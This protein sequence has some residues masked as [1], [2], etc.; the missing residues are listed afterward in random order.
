MGEKIRQ[1]F[2]Y[3]GGIY[4]LPPRSGPAG[5]P[6]VY[7]LGSGLYFKGICRSLG[8]ESLVGTRWTVSGDWEGSVFSVRMGGWRGKISG[9]CAGAGAGLL[10]RLSLWGFYLILLFIIT[11]RTILFLY[12][13]NYLIFRTRKDI[14][15]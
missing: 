2:W 6:K 8:E 7:I 15:P 10:V 3:T 13:T 14:S 5:V 12:E 1:T 4:S 11:I 9:R